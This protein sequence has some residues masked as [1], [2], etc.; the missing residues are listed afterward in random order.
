MFELAAPC[1]Q[2]TITFLYYLLGFLAEFRVDQTPDGVYRP[3]FA[4]PQAAN[5]T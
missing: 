1:G 2:S 4:L 5:L 3:T